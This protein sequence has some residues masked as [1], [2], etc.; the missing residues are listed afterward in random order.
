M[1]RR[2]LLAPVLSALLFSPVLSTAEPLFPN[3]V[4]SNNI[5]F[6]KTSDPSAF[7]CLGYLGQ[8]RKE[9][10]DK[11]GGALMADGVYVFEARF[12]DGARVGIWVHPDMGSQKAAARVA[13]Q[14]SGP[15]GRLP[16]FMRMKLD[17]VVIH[18]GD[19]TA[20]AE[21][22]GH[23]FVLYDQNMAKRI[24]THD[25]E[26]TVFHES[27][28]ATLDHA[29]AAQRAWKKA[30]RRDGGFVT[31]YAAN[32]PGKEDLAETA[33]FAMTYF[34]HPERLPAD[35]RAKL[36]QLVPNRLEFLSEL[37]GADK[38]MQAKHRHLPGC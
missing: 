30:Q 37:F 27:V 20:F 35:V 18:K 15:L 25:L 36:A 11:R 5:D 22:R 19:E 34:L 33:L 1:V 17:H 7:H 13:G 28:H 12:R 14:L 9:M 23:F 26:E 38:Q 32:H 31:T 21:D 16:S 29:I 4:V 24:R 10:P 3:S 8:S 2:F 6:I